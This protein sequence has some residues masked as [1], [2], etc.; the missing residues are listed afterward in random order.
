MIGEK[1][2]D[3]K[4]QAD[5]EK[6]EGKGNPMDDEQLEEVVGGMRVQ[7]CGEFNWGGGK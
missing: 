3:V 7:E 4:I 5:E 1:Q 6:K 2:N